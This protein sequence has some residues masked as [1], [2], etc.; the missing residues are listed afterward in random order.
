MCKKI[1]IFV[2]LV[3]V[4]SSAVALASPIHFPLGVR[5]KRGLFYMER[6]QPQAF[7]VTVAPFYDKISERELKALDAKV[8]TDIIGAEITLFLTDWF[9]IYTMLG[10]T[11]E[12]EYK[13]KI[14]GS[15]VK[16]ELEDKFIWGIGFSSL[17]YDWE[18]VGIKLFGDANLR[19]ATDMDYDALVVD[20]TKYAKSELG[21][22]VDAKWEEWQLALGISKQFQ[23]VIP[24]AGVKYSDVKA[25]AKA[26][27]AGTTYDL[28]STR[29]DK[30]IGPFVGFSIEPTESISI[31]L[32]GRFSDEE[33]FSVSAKIRF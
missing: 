17:I 1:V 3:L 23:Y 9:D 15:D 12:A 8:E 14:L 6:E 30:K 11:N 7:G 26:A 20:G 19:R 10:E 29:S 31:D 5:G 24:Y 22:K 2:C 27:V 18:N 25:S 28:G 32:S 16:F 4:F 21:G 13:A 33:A